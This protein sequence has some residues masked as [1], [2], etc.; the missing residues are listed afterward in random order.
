[1]ECIVLISVHSHDN[2]DIA[3]VLKVSVSECI[4]SYSLWYNILIRTNYSHAD[5][6]IA[7]VPSGDWA[8]GQLMKEDDD[9]KI[10]ALVQQGSIDKLLALEY[11]KMLPCEWTDIKTIHPTN[12]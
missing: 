8:A 12:K 5:N 7:L 6:V 11:H 2:I 9:G 10:L 1:M 3:F 4:V